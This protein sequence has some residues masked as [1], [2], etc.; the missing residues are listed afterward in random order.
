MKE[1]DLLKF[2]EKLLKHKEQDLKNFIKNTILLDDNVGWRGLANAVIERKEERLAL[3][4]K[5]FSEIANSKILI[6]DGKE[7]R[8]SDIFIEKLNYNIALLE[9]SQILEKK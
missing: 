3:F 5:I 7:K 9:V 6:I 2:R 1:N 4:S 8:L